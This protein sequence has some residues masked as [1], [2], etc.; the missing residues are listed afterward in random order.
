M[1]EEGVFSI[2]NNGKITLANKSK[3]VATVTY[4]SVKNIGNGFFVVS[5]NRYSIYANHEYGIVD[6]NLKIIIPCKYKSISGFD[7]NDKL[8]AKKSNGKNVIFS[9]AI[10]NRKSTGVMDLTAEVEYQAKV[11]GFL[12]IGLIVEIN[13]STYIIH[14]K[15]LYKSSR[16]FTKAEIFMAKYLNNDQNGHP[17]WETNSCVK[18]LVEELT[19]N[20]N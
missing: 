12:S 7:S 20:K 1:D 8:E 9:L 5:R 19:E 18:V 10:L 4:D 6:K 13:D 2:Q 11:K 14:K 16:E 17:I 15:Y 3:I